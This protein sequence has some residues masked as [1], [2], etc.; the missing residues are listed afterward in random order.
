MDYNDTYETCERTIVELRIYSDS[1]VPAEISKC[2]SM[3]P[4]TSVTKGQLL[5]SRSG[6]RQRVGKVNSWILSS[7]QHI[8]SKDARRHLDWLLDQ[9]SEVKSA[10][11][12]L[13]SS[14][15]VT[16]YVVC[17]WWSAFGNGG[18]RFWPRQLQRLGELELELEI[19]CAFFGTEPND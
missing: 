19:D 16:L 6:D 8:N 11:G 13:H 15:K 7:E 1:L 5:I 3:T 4:S 10:L 2:L 18:P 9:I 17:I 14:G 12:E